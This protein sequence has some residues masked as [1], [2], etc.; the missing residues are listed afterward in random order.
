[1]SNYGLISRTKWQDSIC[2]NKHIILQMN[3]C[4]E[5]QTLLTQKQNNST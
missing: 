4:L 5:E 2:F 1:M 3:Y